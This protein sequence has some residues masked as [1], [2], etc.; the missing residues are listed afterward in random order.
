[1]R[2]ITTHNI[3]KGFFGIRLC[4]YL[5][6]K[7]SA[8]KSLKFGSKW[9]FLY[10]E[11]ILLAIFVSIATEKVKLTP[12][13]YTW[14]ILLINQLGEI[15][16]KQ[17]SVFGSRGGQICPLMHI[18]LWS[19]AYL[20]MAEEGINYLNLSNQ[21]AITPLV[22]RISWQNFIVM[23]MICCNFFFTVSNAILSDYSWLSIWSTLKC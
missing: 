5:T 21:R 23:N 4:W 18:P 8:W 19:M 13:F 1:M 7:N 22:L 12:E 3:L 14:A 9:Q 6:L 11:P 15:V 16:E 17:L 2:I 20:V 10:F